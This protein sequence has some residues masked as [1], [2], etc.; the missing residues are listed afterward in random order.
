[1]TDKERQHLD[2]LKAKE[3]EEAKVAAEEAAAEAAEKDEKRREEI[4]NRPLFHV[5]VRHMGRNPRTRTLR[6]ARA[7]H[8]R[9]G[10]I[11]DD[12]T[13]IHRKGRKRFTRV[14]L[15]KLVANHRRLLE[16]V[17]VGSIEICD[18][19]TEKFIPYDGLVELISNVAVWVADRENELA[20][21]NHEK[22]MERY[23][24]DHKAWKEA[25]KAA[26]KDKQDPPPEPE[27]PKKPKIEKKKKDKEFK[28][29]Q[30]GLQ[31][32]PLIGSN[33]MNAAPDEV[34]PETG[35]SSEDEDQD[36]G[37]DPTLVNPE[38]SAM[39]AA[40]DQRNAEMSGEANPPPDESGEE[41]E[42]E[43][44]DETEE[45]ENGHTE[46]QLLAMGLDDLK[47]LAIEEYG[48]DE[49][50]INKMKAKKDVVAAIFEAS[51][52]GEE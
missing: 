50:A 22:A 2:E 38:E 25:V 30:S 1:M 36:K 23:K 48:C 51:A 42:E 18:P 13:R 43:N 4:A 45:D 9:Q 8:R 16:F 6:A 31:E 7:G 21:V 33:S 19:K 27:K 20:M 46:E 28:L 11:L 12:G 29:D 49:E 34:P 40:I 47:N 39:A 15:R 35:G 17:R 32:V 26:K 24:E 41:N 10:V 37:E 52:D 14:D 3:A 44:E 5:L